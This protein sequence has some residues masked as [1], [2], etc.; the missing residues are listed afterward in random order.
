MAPFAPSFGLVLLAHKSW[1]RIHD[2]NT[3]DIISEYIT[4]FLEAEAGHLGLQQHREWRCINVVIPMWFFPKDSYSLLRNSEH[5]AIWIPT[6]RE[7]SEQFS[8]V[9][10]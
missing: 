7:I 5:A 6:Y 2:F 10:F 9:A 4:E 8:F 3:F 1:K